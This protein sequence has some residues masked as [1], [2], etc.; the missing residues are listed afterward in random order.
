MEAIVDD[1]ERQGVHCKEFRK[2][3]GVYRQ[4]RSELDG[5]PG[6]PEGLSS[7]LTKPAVR[8]GLRAAGDVPFI[9]AVTEELN[10]DVVA[11]Q[12]DRL[13]AFLSQKFRNHSEVARLMAPVEALTPG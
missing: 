8:I 1:L 7:L 10:A 6:A 2:Q 4:R 9:G 12:V 13:R 5:D 11:S 3:L